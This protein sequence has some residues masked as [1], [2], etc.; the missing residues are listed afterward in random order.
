MYEEPG[1]SPQN[2]AFAVFVVLE[3]LVSSVGIENM[4]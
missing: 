1:P 4:I 2:L 3:D